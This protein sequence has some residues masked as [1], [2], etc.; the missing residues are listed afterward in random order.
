MNLS[1]FQDIIEHDLRWSGFSEFDPTDF[2]YSEIEPDIDLT[3]N[4][5]KILYNFYRDLYNNFKNKLNQPL[6]KQDLLKLYDLLQPLRQAGIMPLFE[7]VYPNFSWELP[8]FFEHFNISNFVDNEVFLSRRILENLPDDYD[9]KFLGS[10]EYGLVFQKTYGNR[11]FHTALK[12][13]SDPAEIRAVSYLAYRYHLDSN[14]Y[15]KYPNIHQIYTIC[16]DPQAE[17]YHYEGEVLKRPPKLKITSTADNE[18]ILHDILPQS[19][20][21]TP[22]SFYSG[23]GQDYRRTINFLFATNDEL[24]YFVNKGIVNDQ[25]REAFKSFVIDLRLAVHQLETL[26][27][28]QRDFWFYYDHDTEEIIMHNIMMNFDNNYVLIDYGSEDL[29]LS[30][31]IINLNLEIPECGSNDTLITLNYKG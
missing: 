10:S 17:L 27:I 11:H 20:E 21:Q 26:G 18:E 9:N 5:Q 14:F 28:Y 29:E 7:K 8:K 30:S 4:Q 24:K 2:S 13:T 25:E 22:V 31:E 12:I 3:L 15:S 16:K 1:Q 19:Y 23:E 6:R